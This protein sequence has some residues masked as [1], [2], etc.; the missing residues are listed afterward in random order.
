[1]T[2]C[3]ALLRGIGPGNPSMRNEHLRRVCE[4]LGLGDVSTVISSGNVVFETDSGELGDLVALETT[5]E[6]AWSEK[7]GFESVTIIRTAGDL[8]RLADLQPFGGLE[9]GKDTYLLVTFAKSALTVDF[10]FLHQ[11]DARAFRLV[12]ATDRE[13]FSV[14]DTTA[15]RTPDVM[16]WIEGQFGKGLTSRT[17]L[18]VERIR[19]RMG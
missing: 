4:E 10:D 12:G 6:R 9:H 18:T 13:L 8:E 5:L 14:T 1:M 19:K 15:T 3:V 17:W 11:P 7:L 2:R 16:G